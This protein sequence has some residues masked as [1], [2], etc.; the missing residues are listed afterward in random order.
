MLP[1]IKTS[2]EN[3]LLDDETMSALY[4]T[5]KLATLPAWQ[6]TRRTLTIW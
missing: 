4:S 1:R 3:Y 5:I 2:W 6:L